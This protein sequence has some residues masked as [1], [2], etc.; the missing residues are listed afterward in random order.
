[1]VRSTACHASPLTCPS[2]GSR[3][4]HQREAL[5]WRWSLPVSWARKPSQQLYKLAALQRRECAY[6]FGTVYEPPGP[7]AGAG[8]GTGARRCRPAA[9]VQANAAASARART[10]TFALIAACEGDARS[11]NSRKSASF[12][13]IRIGAQRVLEAPEL[14]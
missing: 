3:L 10:S 1:M 11:V 4:F 8:T 2:R 9:L 14:P 6:Q 12:A 13:S 5:R 7:G